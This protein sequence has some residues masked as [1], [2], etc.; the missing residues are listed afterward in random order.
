MNDSKLLA[1]TLTSLLARHP[2]VR[3]IVQ[4]GLCAGLA[5]FPDKPL[6][7]DVGMNMPVPMNPWTDEAGLWFQA[8]FNRVSRA[9]AVPWAALLWFGALTA[10]PATR[11]AKALSKADRLR[12]LCAEYDAEEP[13]APNVVHVDFRNRC[14]R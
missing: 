7:L 12:E 11:P 4:P 9:V 3:V 5:D 2:T 6:H 14:R 13:V 8:S 1:D 10:E